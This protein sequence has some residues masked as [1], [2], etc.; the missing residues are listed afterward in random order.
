M[1]K[2]LAFVEKCPLK[3]QEKLAFFLENFLKKT[4]KWPIFR[5]E[6]FLE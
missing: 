4:S 1:V 3:I 6:S 2:I 5:V